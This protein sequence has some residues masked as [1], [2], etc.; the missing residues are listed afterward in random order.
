MPRTQP[1]SPVV[2]F[3]RT[4]ATSSE[5]STCFSKS[6]LR[7][8]RKR[9]VGYPLVEDR[10]QWDLNPISQRIRDMRTCNNSK[11]CAWGG[12]SSQSQPFCSQTDE[13]DDSSSF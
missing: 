4:G 3:I 2:A 8:L 1:S 5:H 6:V 9:P 7:I 12:K 13:D 11:I 10:R